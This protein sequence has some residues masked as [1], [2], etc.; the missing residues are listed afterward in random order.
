[1]TLTPLTYHFD[2]FVGQCPLV[3]LAYLLPSLQNIGN[4]NTPNNHKVGKQCTR[5]VK[6]E[7]PNNKIQWGKCT[8]GHIN[9]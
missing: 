5:V 8:F 6:M 7:I 3:G 2:L 4:K 9:I 1:M